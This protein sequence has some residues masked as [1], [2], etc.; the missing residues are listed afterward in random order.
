MKG[1]FLFDKVRLSSSLTANMM[2]YLR[3]KSPLMYV[4]SNFSYIIVILPIVSKV[5]F[6]TNSDISW[7]YKYATPHTHTIFYKH[8]YSGGEKKT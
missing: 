6:L 2:V 8:C 3:N 4:N 7:K 1:F 5:Y